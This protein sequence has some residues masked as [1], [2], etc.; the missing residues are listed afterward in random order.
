MA[1]R[2]HLDILA[3]GVET[4]NAWRLR[5]PSIIADLGSTDLKS[6]RL[7]AANL[8]GADL[9][10]TS[11]N[12]A[13]LRDADLSRCVLAGANLRRADLTGAFLAEAD[14]HGAWL[15]SAVLRGAYMRAANLS[16][17]HLVRSNLSGTVLD[18]VNFR[19]AEMGEADL[20]DIDLSVVIGL[21]TVKHKGPSS[22]GVATIYRSGGRVSETFLRGAGVPESFIMFMKS[23]TEAAIEFY[24]CFISYSTIDQGFADRLH[25][26]LKARGVRCWFAP[27]DIQGG[28]KVHEQIDEA[29]QVYDRLLLILSD[30]SMNSEWVKTEIAYARQKEVNEK[31]QVLFPI[32]LVPF[33]KIRDWKCF[34][35]DA[36]KDSARE[37]RE[38]FIPDFKN[39]KD[40]DSYQQAFQR[41]VRDLKD[42]EKMRSS[43]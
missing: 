33:D 27:H 20:G 12:D 8:M 18:R 39:W 43:Q 26:D 15:N 19:D 25:A 16:C 9:S 37:I 38:Y 42:T 17:S 36:G 3:E 13:D 4:W 22:I 40:H 21:D 35:A 41:L 24:S 31:R 30:H 32:S 7:R 10:Y 6:A 1:S 34:D 28:R 11:L 23:L 29:I 2:K 14:L 5:N